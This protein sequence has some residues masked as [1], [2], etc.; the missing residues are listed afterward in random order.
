MDADAG[1][2]RERLHVTSLSEQG[3]SSHGESNQCVQV[4]EVCK[5]LRATFFGESCRCTA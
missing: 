2:K 5:W 4:A 1:R 3:E